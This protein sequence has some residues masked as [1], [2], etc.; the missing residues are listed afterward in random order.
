[1]AFATFSRDDSHVPA[2]RARDGT[3]QAVSM[4]CVRAREARRSGAQACVQARLWF[5]RIA[6]ER[7]RA[8]TDA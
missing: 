3:Q 4:A 6:S 8:R 5:R 7:A 2:Q 1:M